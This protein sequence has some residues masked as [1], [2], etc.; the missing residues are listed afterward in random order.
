MSEDGL[1][2]K[3]RKKN[4]VFLKHSASAQNGIKRIHLFGR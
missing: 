3:R 4:V 1:Q 2:T